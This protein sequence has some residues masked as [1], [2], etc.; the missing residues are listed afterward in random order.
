MDYKAVIEEQIRTLQAAQES[1]RKML[2]ARNG[3]STEEV[4]LI[5]STIEHLCETAIR[6]PG[7]SKI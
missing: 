6:M 2:E 3:V 5:A 1:N 7:K 4:C